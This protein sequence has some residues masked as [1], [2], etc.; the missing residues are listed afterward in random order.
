MGT[1]EARTNLPAL[2]RE[3]TAHEEPGSLREHAVEIRP[4]G[5]RQSALLVSSVDVDAMEARLEELEEDLENAGIA[6]YLQDRIG[7]SK[8]V[9]ASE[10]LSGIGMEEFIDEL[11][12][13]R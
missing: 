1:S 13:R 8:R 11:P 5:S 6:L 12:G 7:T 9:G 4:R 3:I 2:V 10:F